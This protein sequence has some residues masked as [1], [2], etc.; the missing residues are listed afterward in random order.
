M[1]THSD[2][3]VISCEHGG[4]D[5][6]PEFAFAFAS[7][8]ATGRRHSHRGYDPGALAATKQFAIAVQSPPHVCTR[9]RLLVDLNRS[10]DNEDL[11]SKFTR[12]LSS[13]QREQ[14]LAIDYF[15]HRRA[16]EASIRTA[17]ADGHRAVHLSIHTFTPRI[18]GKWRPIDVGLLFD[19]ARSGETVFCEQWRVTLSRSRPRLRV[20]DNQPYAGTDDGLTTA[21]RRLFGQDEYLG[22]EVEINHR[23][24]KRNPRTQASIVDSLI[25][26][27]P[28]VSFP[29]H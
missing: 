26:A 22:I 27:M 11:F 25:D 18:G 29:G 16:V 7:A 3:F 14:I 8:H 1:T 15:P 21:L 2:R 6:P 23:Y 9:T 5:V 12:S 19:P 17:I 10:L 4:N 20:F 24:F 28:D 13:S